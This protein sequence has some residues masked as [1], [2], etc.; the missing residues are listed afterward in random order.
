MSCRPAIPLP[1]LDPAEELSEPRPRTRAD[2]ADGP[3]PCPFYSC[4][5]HLGLEVHPGTG[6]LILRIDPEQLEQAP[7]TC[8]LD[9]ADRGGATLEE[10][11]QALGFTRERA[12]QIEER[13]FV[14]LRR[15]KAGRAALQELAEYL[16][17]DPL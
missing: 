11:G 10:I 4:R 14:K 15:T 17:R 6:R 8:A 7:E 1:V 9:V 16:Q 3:R 12:R 13:A 5:Y 2:C